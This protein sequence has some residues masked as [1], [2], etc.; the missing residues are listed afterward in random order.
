[1][2]KY[3]KDGNI[4]SALNSAQADAFISSGYVLLEEDNVGVEKSAPI[5]FSNEYT[6][7]EINRMPKTDLLKLAQ[8]N[9][10]KVSDEMTGNELKTALISHYGL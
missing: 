7:T 10:I 2:R 6:K 5:P 3:I 8:S 1:M 9:G 4:L